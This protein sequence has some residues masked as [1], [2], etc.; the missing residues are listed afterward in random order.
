MHAHTIMGYNE[1]ATMKAGKKNMYVCIREDT[2]EYT[3]VT[4]I[5]VIAVCKHHVI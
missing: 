4:P 5:K 3:L 1:T 2:A